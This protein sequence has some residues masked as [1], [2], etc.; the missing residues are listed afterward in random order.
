MKVVPPEQGFADYYHPNLLA[1]ILAGHAVAPPGWQHITIRFVPAG[2]KPAAPAN[3]LP[4]P[5]AAPRPSAK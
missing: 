3:P 1:D 2:G 5:S 4:P